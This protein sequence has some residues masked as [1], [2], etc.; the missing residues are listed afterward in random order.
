MKY[1]I[2]ISAEETEFGDII[3]KGNLNENIRKAAELGYDGI[4]LAVK[5]PANIDKTALHRELTGGGLE[6][7]VI[8]TGQVFVDHGFSF[9]DS[10]PGKRKAAVEK[11]CE[12]S[13]LADEFNSAVIIGLVRGIL[14]QGADLKAKERALEWMRES[15]QICLSYSEKWKGRFLLEP[16]HRYHTTLINTLDDAAEFI[17]HDYHTCECMIR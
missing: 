4:E 6:L 16:M 1:G 15:L 7:P 12:I 8:G 14:P 11:V 9:A 2:V 3:L 13:E 17:E 10:D 5:N